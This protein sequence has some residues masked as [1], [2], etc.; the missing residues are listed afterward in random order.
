[1]KAKRSVTSEILNGTKGKTDNGGSTV[2]RDSRDKQVG[3]NKFKY[4]SRA[5]R[6]VRSQLTT[7]DRNNVSRENNKTAF[8]Y[9]PTIPFSRFTFPCLKR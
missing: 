6:E 7:L 4:R 2:P 8:S 9:Y 3:H 5:G 1:M